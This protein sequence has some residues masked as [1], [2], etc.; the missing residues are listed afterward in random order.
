MIFLS[1]K[2]F[3]TWIN[4]FER[5]SHYFWYKTWIFFSTFKC[6]QKLDLSRE[7]WALYLAN[8]FY[9]WHLNF[10]WLLDMSYYRSVK[11]KN[12]K[13]NFN[14]K[15]DLAPL[16]V[17]KAVVYLLISRTSSDFTVSVTKIDNPNHTSWYQR[18][19]Q[20]HLVIIWSATS[21]NLNLL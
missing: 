12:G 17:V 2:S 9:D 21:D 4:S 3:G 13:I 8:K 18:M 10:S 5:L 19:P 16:K 6:K 14:K 11:I 7:L 20:V 15:R 1:A